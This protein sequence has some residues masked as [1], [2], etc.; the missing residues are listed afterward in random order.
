MTF[1]LNLKN[2]KTDYS[3]IN[4]LYTLPNNIMAR[5]FHKLTKFS[6]LTLAMFN[7]GME[8]HMYPLIFIFECVHVYV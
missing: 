8:F 2:I 1:F 4:F 7:L 5:F 3:V 6:I